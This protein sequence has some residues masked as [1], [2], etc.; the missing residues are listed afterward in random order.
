MVDTALWY[1]THEQRPLLLGHP[2][3]LWY[4]EATPRRRY[5]YEEDGVDLNATPETPSPLFSKNVKKLLKRIT[6]VL[7]TL[8]VV[9]IMGL[10]VKGWYDEENLMV[11]L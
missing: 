10:F 6:S 1:E 8:A 9:A 5:L 3:P 11:R 7:T 4:Y 2:V